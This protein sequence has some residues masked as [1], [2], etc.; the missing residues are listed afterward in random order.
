MATVPGALDG[1]RV[2]DLSRF[3]A[4]PHCAMILGDL[5]AD[6]LK[7]ERPGSGEESRYFTPQMDGQSMY[8]MAVNRNKRSL[9]LD[10]KDSA[11]IE[12]LKSLVVHADV[13]VENFR[14][15]TLERLGLGWDVLSAL[16][17]QLVL[18]R[19]S[20]YPSDS[21][22]ADRPVFDVVAQ[23]AT[24]LMHL[25]GMPEGRPVPA[26]VYVIDYG[27]SLYAA[28]GILAA[29]YARSN[30]HP[31]QQ[32]LVSLYDTGASYLL[33]GVMEASLGHVIGRNGGRDRYVAPGTTFRTSDDAWIYIIAGSD[34]HFPR[35]AQAIGRP[36]ALTDPRFSSGQARL[37]H[38][39]EV[40][41]LIAEWVGVHTLE[42]VQRTM[43]EHDVLNARVATPLDYLERAR[44]GEVGTV[45]NLDT[46]G[47]TSLPVPASPITLSGT[48][49]TLRH[50]PPPLGDMNDRI[51]EVLAQWSRGSDG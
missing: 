8:F 11:D 29:L 34:E 24:G 7:I 48:P 33:T 2:L 44:T 12:R 31:G 27:A 42:E 28:S 39:D 49:T 41:A 51:E 6:V 15:G 25:T 10:L 14:P 26:G 21:A 22:Y 5:G 32:V 46:G 4:G 17:S 20:G 19:I 47:G 45:L 43:V 50:H 38:I 9:T 18:A 23:A 3:I 36:E 40:E 1:L 30:G 35:L 13:L 37:D 16:N